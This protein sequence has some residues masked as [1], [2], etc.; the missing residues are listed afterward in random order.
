MTGEAPP[1]PRKREALEDAARAVREA[2]GTDRDEILGAQRTLRR[3]EK[4]HDRAVKAA[5]ARLAAARSPHPIAA[6]GHR[7]VLYEDR[8]ST[9]SGNH[10]L[11]RKVSARV[12]RQPGSN[13]RFVMLLEGPGWREEIWLSSREEKRGRAFVA[14][15]ERAAAASDDIIKRRDAELAAA[16]RALEAARTEHQGVAEARPLLRR[17]A[18]LVAEDEEVLDMTPG[19]SAGHDGVAVATDRRFLFLALRRTLAIPYDEIEDAHAKGRWFGARLT[20]E[21]AR[22]RTVV[23]GVNP[24]RATELA[25]LM[26]TRAG[27]QAVA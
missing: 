23:S 1:P 9:S 15:V 17:L 3:A 25:S 22:G 19:V 27:A 4:A 24:T 8:I 2:Q 26:R 10:P 13:K 12:E 7:V 14:E 20:V 21:S 16:D 18:L 5:E 11:D 6:H